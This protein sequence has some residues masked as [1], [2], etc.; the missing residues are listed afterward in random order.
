MCIWNRYPRSVA[1]KTTAQIIHNFPRE[2][3]TTCKWPPIPQEIV[4][5]NDDMVTNLFNLISWIVHLRGQIVNNGSYVTQINDAKSITNN[6]KYNSS[7]AK[8]RAIKRSSSLLLIMH[9]KTGSND[10]VD[11]LH[12]LGHGIS[13]SESL[14]I[15]DKWV[16][17]SQCQSNLIPSNVISGVLATL[18]SY[19]F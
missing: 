7:A 11:T 15:K 17:C 6:T 3:Q 4:E 9:V 2:I 13:Y 5:S 1:I 18:A 19:N 10:V 16:E 8:Y 12:H 14:F